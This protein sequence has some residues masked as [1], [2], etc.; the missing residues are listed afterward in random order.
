MQD[1]TGYVKLVHRLTGAQILV[2]GAAGH[3]ESSLAGA[4]GAGLPPSGDRDR[5]RPCLRRALLPRARVRRRVAGGLDPQS[6]P[7]TTWRRNPP[8]MGDHRS[9]CRA[10]RHGAPDAPC[11]V[12]RRRHLGQGRA[13][14]ARPGTSRARR[15]A[16]RSTAGAA[17]DNCSP[18][19]CDSP[20]PRGRRPGRRS[21]AW[22]SPSP[23]PATTSAA[24]PAIDDG[25]FAALAGVDLRGELRGRL[26]REASAIVFCNDAEAADRR[27]GAARRRRPFDRVLGITLGAGLGACLVAGDAIVEA[28]AAPSCPASSTASPSAPHRRRRLLRPWPAR[29]AR[30]RRSREAR[31]DDALR[32]FAGFG[33]DL[34]AFLAP[35]TEVLR[36]DAVVVAGGIAGAFALFGPALGAA[37]AVPARAGE[38][39]RG[40]GAD[41]RRPRHERRHRTR[42][43]DVG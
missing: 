13:R 11:R 29:P 43:A 8:G 35:W 4:A 6:S 5:R 12:G 33:A 14:R 27:R 24:C 32:A 17:S 31:D 34:G 37:L 28:S 41:R 39:R 18:R 3:V 40:R 20:A 7:L 19:W 21:A 2:R 23:V 42:R 26:G 25:K 30:G 36:A 1:V 16:R 15:S 22:R 38:T 10:P 9:P